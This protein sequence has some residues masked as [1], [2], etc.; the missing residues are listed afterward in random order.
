MT[1]QLIINAD[2][3]G[4]GP[5]ATQG[6]LDAIAAGGP[7]TSVSVNANFPEAERVHDLMA[8]HPEISIGVHVNPI[9]GAPCL[10][11]AQVPTLVGPDGQFHGGRFRS[12]W[13]RGRISI[14]ELEAELDRQ[15]K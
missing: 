2:G 12:L 15:L 11:P 5:G 1:R 4:F 7:I 6:I 10:P 9:V 8:Q 13:R 14:L 3:F